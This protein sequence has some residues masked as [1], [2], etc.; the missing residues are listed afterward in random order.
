[1]KKITIKKDK[2]LIKLA[3]LLGRSPDLLIEQMLS[4]AQR[5]GLTDDVCNVQMLLV[6]IFVLHGDLY[7]NSGACLLCTGSHDS[8]IIE[9]FEK[10]IIRGVGDCPECGCESEESP[11]NRYTPLGP[12]PCLDQPEIIGDELMVC[13]K[14]KNE[15]Y[16]K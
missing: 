14:C 10:L 9:L 6:D 11:K 8:R 2:S 16:K 13:M 15:F 1:M 7:T 4:A 12:H 3:T 5:E